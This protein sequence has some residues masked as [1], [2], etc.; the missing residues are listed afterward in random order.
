M[1]QIPTYLFIPSAL[2]WKSL[3]INAD[4]QIRRF[5][6]ELFINVLSSTKPPIL[7]LLTD[8]KCST[9]RTV[10]KSISYIRQV[11]KLLPNPYPRSNSALSVFKKSFKEKKKFH[12]KS[13]FL[14]SSPVTQIS[15][16]AESQKTRQNNQIWQHLTHTKIKN[17][18]EAG[19]S[20]WLESLSVNKESEGFLLLHSGDWGGGHRSCAL[21]LSLSLY[22]A[23]STLSFLFVNL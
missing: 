1:D 2:N 20:A 14:P 8:C 9:E 22:T 10:W 17:P 16:T 13:E 19:S 5:K 11:S 21:S 18:R 6:Y 4:N 15:C 23:L 12:L 7:I 3:F